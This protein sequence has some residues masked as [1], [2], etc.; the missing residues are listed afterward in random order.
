MADYDHNT[1]D[2]LNEPA[3]T[4]HERDF[5]PT[6]PEPFDITSIATLDTAEMVINHPVTGAPTTWVWIIAGPGHPA[7]IA[8]DRTASDESRREDLQ[9]EKARVNGRKWSGDFVDSVEQQQKNAGYFAKKVLGWSP[10][11]INGADLAYSVPN[12]VKILI[13]PH[14]QTVYKQ[15]IDFL[16]D[17]KSFM[18]PSS[19][20]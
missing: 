14:Y 1:D 10:V 17:E 8:A 11:R 7:A 12:V 2:S 16:V 4:A 9:K 5:P 3:Q 20:T 13:D 18:K 6:P 19:P 15:L